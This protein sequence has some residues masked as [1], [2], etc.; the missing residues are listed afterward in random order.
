MS[1][2]KSLRRVGGVSGP[3]TFNISTEHENLEDSMR[4]VF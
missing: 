3:S 1:V 2:A 4:K